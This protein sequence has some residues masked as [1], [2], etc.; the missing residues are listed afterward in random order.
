[1]SNAARASSAAMST[2]SSS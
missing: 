1:M 2:R